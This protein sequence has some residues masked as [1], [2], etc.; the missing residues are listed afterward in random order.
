MV[1]SAGGSWLRGLFP[2]QQKDSDNNVKVPLD[3]KGQMQGL[4]EKA[5][6]K[7]KKPA[8]AEKG[9]VQVAKNA[10]PNVQGEIRDVQ[11]LA[12]KTFH[13]SDP[14]HQYSEIDYLAKAQGHKAK[15]AN[16]P[17][18]KMSF[19]QKILGPKAAK[20][21]VVTETTK[22]KEVG[23]KGII[24]Q[25]KSGKV[26][27]HTDID[28][29]NE[30]KSDV[31]KALDRVAGDWGEKENARST[32]E[33]ML[34]ID[35]REIQGNPREAL[36][37][38]VSDIPV[39]DQQSLIRELYKQLPKEIQ[40]QGATEEEIVNALAKHNQVV[41]EGLVDMGE[42]REAIIAQKISMYTTRT[43]LLLAQH[44]SA[45]KRIG[46]KVDSNKIPAPSLTL[47]ED[48]KGVMRPQIQ[49]QSKDNQESTMLAT[50][51][52]CTVDISVLCDPFKGTVS[53]D[54]TFQPK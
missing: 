27:V 23:T 1:N 40:K 39:K 12:K 42:K 50:N 13:I 2:K 6:A 49:I 32:Q 4:P 8:K 52:K 38:F 30:T 14:N 46:G 3:K 34:I 9:H 48:E 5:I 36:S 29:K 33:I 20:P 16:Q 43:S 26:L 54:I 11:P 45:P 41:T 18:A 51:K 22:I 7:E 53:N 28:D 10:E 24:T 44:F 31:T 19:L 35:G 15:V 37:N 21:D 17:K 47:V 25:F